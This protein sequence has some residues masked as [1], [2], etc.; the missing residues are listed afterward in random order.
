MSVMPGAQKGKGSS[1]CVTVPVLVIHK[2]LGSVCME[3]EGTH[4][5][6]LLPHPVLLMQEERCYT[7]LLSACILLDE[8]GERSM[9]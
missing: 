9:G 6:L 8:G 2:S 4:P 5:S 1:I 7:S 3:E